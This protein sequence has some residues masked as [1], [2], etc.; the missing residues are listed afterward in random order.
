MDFRLLKDIICVSSTP[1]YSGYNTKLRRNQYCEI[2][3]KT[4]VLYNPLLDTSTIL[5]AMHAVE[6]VTKEAEQEITMLMRNH[7]LYRVAV[8][9]V[10][11]DPRQWPQFFSRLGGI[12][13][14]MSFIG[15]VDKLMGGSGLNMLMGK[16][17]A[18]VEKLLLGGK[19]L[20]NLR[21]LGVVVIELLRDIIG[22]SPTV[23]VFNKKLTEPFE[24]SILADHWIKNLIDPLL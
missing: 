5:T 12:Y 24:K 19:F 13:M 21:A 1:E 3:S 10:W 9:I 7:Q 23:D 17:L 18:G 2:K 14:L 4:N 15:C 8:N 22:D 6:K 20:M 11:A 16:A